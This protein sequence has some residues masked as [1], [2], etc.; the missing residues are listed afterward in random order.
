M[1]KWFRKDNTEGYTD[2]TLKEMNSEMKKQYD[3]LS[4]EEKENESYI[5]HLMEKILSQH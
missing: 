3:T 4:D 2:E 5:D 1:Q